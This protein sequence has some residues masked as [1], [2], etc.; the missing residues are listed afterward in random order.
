MVVLCQ[1][2]SRHRH[3]D[4][5]VQNSEK[6]MSSILAI[7]A[8][9]VIWNLY[10]FATNFF[11]RTWKGAPIPVTFTAY[12]VNAT[13]IAFLGFGSTAT[14]TSLWVG[15]IL[16]ALMFIWSA[17]GVWLLF[18]TKNDERFVTWLPGYTGPG[19]AALLGFLVMVLSLNG[20]GII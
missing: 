11:N 2:G 15:A 13:W 12:L 20:L 16:G 5:L 7:M 19:L 18:T 9:T 14:P 6:G 8:A 4:S 3:L 1:L 10:G 17:V